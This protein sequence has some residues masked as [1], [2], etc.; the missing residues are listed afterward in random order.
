LIT[1]PGTPGKQWAFL[2]KVLWLTMGW[3]KT[4]GFWSGLVTHLPKIQETTNAK[5]VSFP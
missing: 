4:V 1:I 5:A 3:V 2:I